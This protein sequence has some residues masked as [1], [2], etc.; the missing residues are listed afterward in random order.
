MRTL[1]LAAIIAAMSTTSVLAQG[2]DAPRITQT[3]ELSIVVEQIN[4]GEA[5]R[6]YLVSIGVSLE[7]R[8]SR[9]I[10]VAGTDPSPSLL[11][12]QGNCSFARMSLPSI[13]QRRNL[14][15]SPSSRLWVQFSQ[16]QTGARLG[17]GIVF[18]FTCSRDAVPGRAQLAF[19]LAMGI[20]SGDGPPARAVVIQP[21]VSG[22]R[23]DSGSR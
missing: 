14:P 5:G 4:V 2:P 16:I 6:D 23:L 3:R 10:L 19:A 8:L 15:D 12:E 11:V 1:L 22:M 9:D 7:N 18:S 17:L 21:T 13:G 20:E